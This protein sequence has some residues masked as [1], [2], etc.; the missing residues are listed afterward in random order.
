MSCPGYDIQASFLESWLLDVVYKDSLGVPVDIST[1]WVVEFTIGPDTYSS[2]DADVVI[3]GPEAGTIHL[4]LDPTTLGSYS[5]D[6][7]VKYSLIAIDPNVTP[8]LGTIL[9][10][11]GRFTVE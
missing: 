7:I 2:D 3:I 1:A 10:L 5:I 8:G 11:E 9:L 6:A 4:G